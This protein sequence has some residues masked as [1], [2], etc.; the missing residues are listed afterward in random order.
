AFE[1]TYNGK[2][3]KVG[4]LME[5]YQNLQDNQIIHMKLLKA[6]NPSLEL[7]TWDLMMKNVY[8]LDAT[9]VN[10][11]NFQLQIVYKDDETGVDITSLKEASPIQGVPL[12]EVLNLDNV[13]T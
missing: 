5:D 10:R 4:E 9:Q 11:E 8:S 6:T 2:T 12:V 7:P 3:Y 13:N 1:Y